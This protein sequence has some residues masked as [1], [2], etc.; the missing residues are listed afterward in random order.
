MSIVFIK[1]RYVHTRLATTHLGSFYMQNDV[2]IHFSRLIE[3]I[4]WH[5]TNAWWPV[6]KTCTLAPH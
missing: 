3:Q 6:S 5:T 1:Q 4:N 2:T